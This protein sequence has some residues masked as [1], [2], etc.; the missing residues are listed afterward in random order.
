MIGYH[1]PVL[2]ILLLEHFRGLLKQSLVDPGRDIPMFFGDQLVVTLG[3]RLGGGAALE[4]FGERHVVEECP[5][6]VEFG[7]PGPFEVP[8]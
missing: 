1:V 3:F 8:H 6:V 7:V 5:R 4:F 2:D